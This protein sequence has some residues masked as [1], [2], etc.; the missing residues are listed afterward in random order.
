M[1]KVKMLVSIAAADW[2]YS[3]NEVVEVTEDTAKTWIESGIA[4]SVTT[5]RQT[6]TVEPKEKATRKAPSRRKKG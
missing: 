5:R 2:S 1:K 6:A 3:P 4:E